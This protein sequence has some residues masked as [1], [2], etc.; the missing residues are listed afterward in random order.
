[1]P[2]SCYPGRRNSKC[3]VPETDTP[4]TERNP[5]GLEEREPQ[6][7]AGDKMRVR[8][9]NAE[10]KSLGVTCVET[11]LG[12]YPKHKEKEPLENCELQM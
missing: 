7:G 9:T 10:A 6:G 3:T 12:F 2:G 11:G 8:P 1:M 4:G 5:T